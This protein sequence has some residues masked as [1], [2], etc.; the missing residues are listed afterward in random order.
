MLYEGS[1]GPD[2]ASVQSFLNY[3]SGGTYGIQVDGIFGPNTK[4]AVINF[5]QRMGLNP[6]GIIG[7]FT[8]AVMENLGYV[9]VG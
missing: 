7:P 2:V 5:Q 6:D 3:E 4:Q 8:L 9:S 1:S